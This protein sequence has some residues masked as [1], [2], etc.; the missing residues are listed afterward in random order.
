MYSF[1]DWQF[2]EGEIDGIYYMDIVIPKDKDGLNSFLSLLK[3]YGFH[4]KLASNVLT[5]FKTYVLHNNISPEQKEVIDNWTY[6]RIFERE[7]ANMRTEIRKNNRY[8]Y[9]YTLEKYKD[10]ILTN[11]LGAYNISHP[12]YPKRVFLIIKNRPDINTKY[13]GEPKF[14]INTY[15][16]ALLDR[17]I[18]HHHRTVSKQ[19]FIEVVIDIDRLPL[20]IQL[21]FDYNS[22]PYAVYTKS[23]IPAEAII[24]IND[25]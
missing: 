7:D 6:I 3:K 17:L 10:S 9:H 1:D 16:N 24:K 2:S 21:S 5:D 23:A 25:L 4:Y 20:D 15:I 8:L 22:Y 19:D 14:R 11:G 13:P 12:E 18:E